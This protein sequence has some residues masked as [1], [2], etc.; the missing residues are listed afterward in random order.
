MSR[1]DFIKSLFRSK[2]DK[3]YGI[4]TGVK[5]RDGKITNEK[6]IIVGVKKKKD[7]SLLTKD[8]VVP[9]SV[10]GV[11]TDVVE[12]GDLE[13]MWR[14]KH[15]PMKV[16]ASCCSE[17]VTACSFGLPIYD[18]N[19]DPYV[20]MNRHCIAPKGYK[21]GDLIVN[22]SPVD[23]KPE[24]I[25]VLTEIIYPKQ[26]TDNIDVAVAKL[27][28]APLHEDVE[29]NTYIPKTRRLTNSD[30]LKSF[31]GGSRTLGDVRE[32]VGIIS[33]DFEAQVRDESG[34]IERYP[35]CV[36]AL[37]VEKG[38]E[39]PIVM[40][41]CSSSIRFIDNMPL[42]QVFAG[43]ELVGVLNQTQISLDWIEKTFGKKFY[44]EPPVE[45][46]YYIA[47]GKEWYIEPPTET[48]TTVRL[49]LRSE[50]RVHQSTLIRTLPIG[51][52]IKVVENLGGKD[53]QWLKIQL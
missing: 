41:G 37:N 46:S 19:G 36:L 34:V 39:R 38:T 7:L 32:S 1:Y 30:L 31:I 51:T 12:V 3:G 18:E 20:L 26:L 25:G 33:I 4:G 43:S 21:I 2:L 15:R 6:C 13:L 47:A 24:R 11:K 40:G 48:K 45:Q 17:K 27:D 42:V 8:E 29:G 5:I 28:K 49:N 53:Y 50:P 23:G 35:D 9:K 16:G 14:K 52:Q 22:P 10:L 44:L